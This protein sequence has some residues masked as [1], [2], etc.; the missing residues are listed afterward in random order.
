MMNTQTLPCVKN[1]K[2]SHSYQD[3]RY[4]KQVRVMNQLTGKSD[5]KSFR[6]TVC[7]AVKT[8]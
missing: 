1:C 2:Q 6:C 4:G 5:G 7:G 3:S 8:L